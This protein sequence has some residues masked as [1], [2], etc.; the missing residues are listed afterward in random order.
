LSSLRQAQDRTAKATI[1]T[2]TLMAIQIESGKACPVARMSKLY[3]HANQPTPRSSANALALI[4]LRP[5][6]AAALPQGFPLH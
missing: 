3:L 2:A 1:P 5:K 4:V 6:T